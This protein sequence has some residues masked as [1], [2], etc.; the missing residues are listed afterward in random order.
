VRPIIGL[1]TLLILVGCGSRT[2]KHSGP[3]DSARPRIIVGDTL[4]CNKLVHYVRPLY[5]KEAK[6]MHIQG[7][8]EVRVVITKAGNLGNIE[9]LKGDPLLVPAAL[10]AVKNWRYTPCLLNSQ[11]VD[12]VAVL[13]ISFNLNQ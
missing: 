3:D 7:I 8:V 12:V 13:D 9:V 6:G 1:T 2:P 4:N 5:P 11:A 10:A